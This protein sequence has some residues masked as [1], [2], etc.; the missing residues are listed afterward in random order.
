MKRFSII[1]ALLVVG[2][3][4]VNAVFLGMRLYQGVKLAGQSH[5]FQLHKNQAHKRVLIVGDNTGVGT[6]A[7]E[8]AHSIAGRISQ[9][10][11]AAEIINLSRNG[12]GIPE[13]LE[14][15][16]SVEEGRFDVI[17]IQAGSIDIL[18]LKDPDEMRDALS[19]LFHLA[20]GRASRVIF[21]GAGNIGLAPA[22]F[23]PVS[24]MYTER[25]G[26]AREL[27]ILQ[28]RQTGVE[29]VDLFRGQDRDLFRKDPKRF[30]AADLLHPGSDGYGLWYRDLM[31]QSSLAEALGTQ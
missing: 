2:A 27:F 29:Y 7:L 11:P 28:S 31:R 23:P 12:A 6:G 21:M 1:L 9:D 5:A 25:A 15:L 8:P 4:L 17:L 20:L 30:F 16:L 14:Q 13:V 3:F 22:F 10:F 18:R 24:W 19:R 26:K